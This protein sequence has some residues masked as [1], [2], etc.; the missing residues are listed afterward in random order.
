LRIVIGLSAQTGVHHRRRGTVVRLAR[1]TTRPAPCITDARDH[2]IVSGRCRRAC[3]P[4]HC[5]AGHHAIAWPVIVRIGGLSSPEG[6]LRRNGIAEEQWHS[7]G[8][9]VFAN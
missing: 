5:V 6:E 7:N 3:I 8:F 2:L 4:H 1:V 9:S